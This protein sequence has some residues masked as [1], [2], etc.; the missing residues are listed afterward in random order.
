MNLRISKLLVFIIFVASP[1]LG[2]A[3]KVSPP[4]KS[5]HLEVHHRFDGTASTS[6]IA[7]QSAHL[8][9]FQHYSEQSY[10]DWFIFF[11]SLGK[12]RGTGEYLKAGEIYFH[13][14]P[15]FSIPRV[16]SLGRPNSEAVIK[17]YYFVFRYNDSDVSY[18]NRAV[19]WGFSVDL[20]YS[21]RWAHSV[22]A[23]LR[24]ED[25]HKTAPHIGTV[26][27][28]EF[29]IGAHPFSFNGFIDYYKNDAGWVLN[30]QPQILWSLETMGLNSV[31]L[32]S[33]Q[34]IA[35]NFYGTDTG[36]SWMPTIFMKVVF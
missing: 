29:K 27:S 26:W 18:L 36:W 12:L 2:L 7:Q 28:T 35:H 1:T 20:N 8:L 25:N 4:L 24:K 16:L 15:R 32:G 21:D 31:W 23:Y 33:E 13:V 14:E 3:E 10:G 11:D 22:T 5:T 19:L 17:D 30:A 6:T 9:T 34:Q